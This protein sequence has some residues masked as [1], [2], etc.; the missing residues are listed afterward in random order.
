MWKFKKNENKNEK[1]NEKKKRN[2]T[3]FRLDKFTSPFPSWRT[4][5]SQPWFRVPTSFLVRS[6]RGK[7]GRVEPVFSVVTV[8]FQRR[9]SE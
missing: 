8:K 9:Q 7:L 6:G 4:R 2:S 1:K 5:R 3:I